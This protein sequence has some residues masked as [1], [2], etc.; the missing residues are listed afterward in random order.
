[1]EGS[2]INSL[3]QKRTV[4]ESSNFWGLNINPYGVLAKKLR[5]VKTF[6]F[7]DAVFIGQAP[8]AGRG[9]AQKIEIFMKSPP[10]NILF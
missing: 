5:R 6:R 1:M 3:P 8:P 10:Q 7:R 2:T 4:F 9:H